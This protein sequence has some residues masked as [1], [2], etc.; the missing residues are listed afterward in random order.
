M[1]PR[2]SGTFL[3]RQIVRSQPTRRVPIDRDFELTAHDQK[4]R[5]GRVGLSHEGFAW[6]ERQSIHPGHQ[7]GQQ[8]AGNMPECDLIPER[9]KG[10]RVVSRRALVCIDPKAQFILWSINPEQLQAIKC[11][12][13]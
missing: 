12:P 10:R 7:A 8:D 4:H 3:T 11:L 9:R 2:Q 13:V 6:C 1:T 5:I